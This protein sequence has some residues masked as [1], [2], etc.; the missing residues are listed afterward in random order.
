[1]SGPLGSVEQ[2]EH[3]A[4][5]GCRLVPSAAVATAAGLMPTPPD[6]DPGPARRRGGTD[7]PRLCA[8]CAEITDVD[9]A[10]IMLLADGRPQGSVCTSD[11]ISTRIEELQ[12]TLGEGPCIDAHRQHVPVAEPDLADPMTVR[13]TAF[14][15]AAVAAGARAVFG[16]PLS[17][18]GAHVGAM[19]LYR[20]RPGAL[21]EEQHADALVMADVAARAILT[22][23]STAAPGTIAAELEAGGNFRFVVHQASGM[24]AAQSSVPV[25]EAL[26][27][28]RAHAFVA[29][30]QRD[31]RGP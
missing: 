25:D 5:L 28:I 30:P 13:W 23:Q 2:A 27:R 22:M 20:N 11:D 26:R 15:P 18:G 16:F 14:S 4:D 1:M 12:Y 17:V 19:N 29:R 21:S 31:R 7:A 6:P 24:V 3:G 10:G 9:G 8:V